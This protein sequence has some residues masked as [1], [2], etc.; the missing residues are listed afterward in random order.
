M[1]EISNEVT[2][3][4]VYLE[5]GTLIGWKDTCF[6]IPIIA[7][8]TVGDR[9]RKKRGAESN[10]L[11]NEIA[12]RIHRFKR[13]NRPFN[14]SVD[15]HPL[16]FC[17]MVDTL[18]IGCML[19]NLLELWNL[20]EYRVKHLNKDDILNELYRTNISQTTG[21]ETNFE[22][23]LGGITRNETGHIVAAK[24]LL[25][26]WMI[27]VNFSNVNH[28]KVGNSAGTEDWVSEEALMW[29]NQFLNLMETLSD[30]LSDNETNIYYSAGRR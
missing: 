16:I 9:R 30:D 26:H 3:F 12:E 25:T 5:N 24:G 1:A 19:Q 15:V 18:P 20:D 13:M 11:L 17:A 7:S 22:R 29:E 6:Q 4:K 2:N 28:D 14:P 8:L 21:H 23:L 27:Y 10:R